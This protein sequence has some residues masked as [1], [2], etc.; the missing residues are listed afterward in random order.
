[1]ESALSKASGSQ[2]QFLRKIETKLKKNIR[3]HQINGRL[4]TREKHLYSIYSK[5]QRKHI[6]LSEIV[7]VFGIR[8]VVSDIDT[9][10]RVLGLVHQIYKPMPGR[11]KDYISI[12]R[13]NGYQSLHTTLFGPKGMPL[14]V[15]IRTEE[16]D[17]VAER[18]IAAPWQLSL[19]H[20]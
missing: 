7:D 20:I 14:E 13:V 16:M 8:I 9:C 3:D 2:R 17:Q 10:Y 19:I 15:Q 11:F 5:M 4:V 18:G 6:H 1:M 12:P